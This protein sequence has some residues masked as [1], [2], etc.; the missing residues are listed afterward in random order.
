MA[1]G[2]HRRWPQLKMINDQSCDVSLLPQRLVDSGEESGQVSITG[3]EELLLK[4][5]GCADEG[6]KK[7]LFSPMCTF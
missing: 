3:V 4:L 1:G 5:A 2:G 6:K 7:Q